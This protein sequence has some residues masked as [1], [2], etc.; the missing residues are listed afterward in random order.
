V[1]V[2]KEHIAGTGARSVHSHA[3]VSDSQQGHAALPTDVTATH[4]WLIN[5]SHTR[6]F[7]THTRVKMAGLGAH[8]S[9]TVVPGAKGAIQ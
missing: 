9:H 6:R 4:L 7:L 3:A 8:Q 2:R 5:S 1:V